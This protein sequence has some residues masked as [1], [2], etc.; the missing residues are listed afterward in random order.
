MLQKSRDGAIPASRVL[1]DAKIAELAWSGEW[2]KLMALE[3]QLVLGVRTNVS[4][5]SRLRAISFPSNT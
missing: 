5:I 2:K 3:V 4:V 1:A